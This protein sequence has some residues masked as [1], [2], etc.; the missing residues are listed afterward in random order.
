MEGPRVRRQI[1]G[2][3]KES[4]LEG[5]RKHG[6]VGRYC[7]IWSASWQKM[8]TLSPIYVL[9]KAGRLVV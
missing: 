6:K 1:R 3:H 8:V 4:G 2:S 7:C 9:R 5:G